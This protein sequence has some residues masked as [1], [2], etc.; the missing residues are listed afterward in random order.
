MHASVQNK[1]YLFNCIPLITLKQMVF[2]HEAVPVSLRTSCGFY[3]NLPLCNA[4]TDNIW[5]YY[6]KSDIILSYYIMFKVRQ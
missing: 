2:A 3:T 4:A 1:Y 5:Q 6:P